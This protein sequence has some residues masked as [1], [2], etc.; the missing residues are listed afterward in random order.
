MTPFNIQ[1]RPTF[2]GNDSVSTDAASL[3]SHMSHC[4]SSQSRFFGLQSAL[5]SAQ[6]MLGPRVVTVGALLVMVLGLFAAA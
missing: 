3:A 4:A 5:Q 2:P 1:S 6:A